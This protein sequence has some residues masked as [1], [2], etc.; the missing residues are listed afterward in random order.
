MPPLA[1]NCISGFLIPEIGDCAIVAFCGL[2]FLIE[3]HP[4]GFAVVGVAYAIGAAGCRTANGLGIPSSPASGG[5]GSGVTYIVFVGA[6]SQPADM[7]NI[8][9]IQS[10]G[11]SLTKRLISNNP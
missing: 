5:V 6:G 8:S 4:A 11:A 3:A 9:E 10:L 1:L 2:A 7:E